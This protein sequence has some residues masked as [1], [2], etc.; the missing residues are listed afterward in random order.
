MS[1]KWKELSTAEKVVSVLTYTIG[2]AALIL[3]IIE[4]CTDWNALIGGIATT[5]IG[6]TFLGEAFLVRKDNRITA[7]ISVI[8]GVI[9]VGLGIASI[10]MA[11]LPN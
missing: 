5:L 4:I 10:V 6:T 1:K 11:A 9:V 3:F 7:I 2:A 8:M